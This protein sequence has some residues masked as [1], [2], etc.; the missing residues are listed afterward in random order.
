MIG[1]VRGCYLSGDVW[2]DVRFDIYLKW[3]LVPN[4]PLLT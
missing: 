2:F 1:D 4:T 3:I